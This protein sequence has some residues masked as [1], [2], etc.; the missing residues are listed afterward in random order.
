MAQLL[1]SNSTLSLK[2]I[3]LLHNVDICEQW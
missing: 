3:E 1:V 2:G